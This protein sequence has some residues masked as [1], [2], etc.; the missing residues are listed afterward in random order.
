MNNEQ[1]DPTNYDIHVNINQK[2]MNCTWEDEM[3]VG[4]Y[5]KKNDE[6]NEESK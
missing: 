2:E 6:Q 4:D 1:F 5:S 3:L